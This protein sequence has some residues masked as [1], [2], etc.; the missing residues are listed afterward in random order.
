MKVMQNKMNKNKGTILIAEDNPTNMKLLRD[1]LNF[2]GYEIIE[3]YDG[4][5]AVEQI[6]QNKDKIDL[7][8]M[9]LQL[10]EMDG[11]E[12]IK[13]VKSDDSTKHLPVFVISAHAMESDM[14]KALKAGC[15]N[16]ITKPINLEDFI[17]KIN[18]FFRHK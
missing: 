16:Y 8:L 18:A 14:R 15:N 13:L 7:I 2:Q 3:T 10:P 9:D 1:I 17:G 5:S 11:I 12:V 6:K 4:K